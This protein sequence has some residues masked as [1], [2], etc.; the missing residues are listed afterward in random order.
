MPTKSEQFQI[1]DTDRVDLLC[2]ARDMFTAVQGRMAASDSTQEMTFT[3][4]AEE[5]AYKAAMH[6][7]ETELSRGACKVK[8]LLTSRTILSSFPENEPAAIG[9]NKTA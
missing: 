5:D 7:L 4:Q 8:K 2:I 9:A 6:L 3:S 1:L